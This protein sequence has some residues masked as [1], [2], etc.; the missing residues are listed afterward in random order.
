MIRFTV[1]G[2][3]DLRDQDGVVLD[4]LLRQPKRLA[5]LAYLASP[6]P[7]TWH[8]R[9][10]LLALF[11]PDLDGGRARTS[12][13]NALY[14]LRQTLG[15]GVVRT[16]GD[17][18][19]SVDP[20][21]VE[22]DLQGL[23][24]ALDAGCTE[25]ALALYR[26]ELLPG[27]FAPAS[28]GFERW[29]EEERARLRTRV[30]RAAADLS[31][32][33]ER[34][35]RLGPAIFA[36]EK[37]VELDPDDEIA[38]RR[39]M[40]LFG[41]AGDRAKALALFERFKAR[42]AA[43]FGAEPAAETLVLASRL[44]SQPALP[45]VALWQTASPSLPSAATPGA[46]PASAP[47][48]FP[49]SAPESVAAARIGRP[50][51]DAA[52]A[53][54]GRSAAR[55]SRAWLAAG[56]AA[57]AIVAAAI[58]VRH[59]ATAP[60]APAHAVLVLPMANH[61][62]RT[63]DDYIA[64]GV[65]E[66][67]ARA[68]RRAPALRVMSAARS[69]LRPDSD[70]VAFG[71]QV[72]ATDVLETALERAGDGLTV[73][74]A[75]IAVPSGERRQVQERALDVADLQRGESELA[76]TVLGALFRAPVPQFTRGAGAR[77]DPESYRLTL[78]G[79][80]LL[81][82]ERQQEPAKQRF[83]AAVARDPGNVRAWAGLSSV[84]A[85]LG[86]SGQASADDA[87]ARAE[88]A[89]QRA[90]A[91]DST[92]GTAW[93]NLGHIRIVRDGDLSGGRRL[94]E[95]AKEVDPGNPEIYLVE[96]VSLRQT[97]RYDEARAAIR[98]ARELDPFT[99]RYAEREGSLYLCEGKAREALAVYGAALAIDSANPAI[100]SEYVRALARLGR[101]DEAIRTWA[102]FA[103][104]PADSAVAAVLAG[105]RGPAGYWAARHAE[106]RPALAR[107]I[108]EARA[109]RE[110]AAGLAYAYIGAG[111]PDSGL[112]LLERA[113]RP[114]DLPLLNLACNPLLDEVRG[115]PRFAALLARFGH[116]GAR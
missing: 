35:G 36:A 60:G 56:L 49:A 26:G 77:I 109:G 17:E 104:A 74:S 46:S 11:W 48:S 43:E 106:N 112:A 40:R 98:V 7:G 85:S 28:G 51:P 63:T 4:D 91:I 1:L 2:G 80:D 102:R 90:L 55:R 100:R 108:T 70:P 110:S 8:R 78:E 21:A 83:L 116:L 84:W 67:L 92:D 27:F 71:R 38:V 29:L 23:A 10:S 47:E 6:S 14:V 81:I 18:D 30:A 42:L 16:R 115:E 75:L 34:E 76:A 66:D 88:A 107:Q 31:E 95:R 62:G 61:T 64:T 12:L 73:R 58:G 113:A 54:V 114:E 72:G 99:M 22:T 15:D 68:L 33:R 3:I 89:A 79:W 25:E 97:G 94:I 20:E 103:T 9:D 13:R 82:G 86:V 111:F 45:A 59:S 37:A 87:F 41:A 39:L 53:G 65:A 24:A 69:E 101:W 32:A 57:A 93:A 50:E 44:R 19:V 105:A 5:L 52:P 96:S